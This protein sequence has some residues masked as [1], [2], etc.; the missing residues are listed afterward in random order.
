[1]R[2]SLDRVRLSDGKGPE[3]KEKEATELS[4]IMSSKATAIKVTFMVIIIMWLML[5][6]NGNC[7]VFLRDEWMALVWER[8]TMADNKMTI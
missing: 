1:M 8:V 2:S 3:E 4:C 5:V 6:Q 7:T